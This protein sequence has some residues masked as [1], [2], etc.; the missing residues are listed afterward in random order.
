MIRLALVPWWGWVL[1]TLA[2]VAGV[3]GYGSVRHAAGKRIG[4]GEV[5]AQW[6][7]AVERG[8]A[9]VDRLKAAAGRVTTRVETKY[10]DRI[11]TIRE[12]GDA[13]VREVPVFVPAGSCDLPGG[14]RLLHDA[15]AAAGP[16][17]EAAGIADA[18]PVPAQ[19]AIATVAGNYATCHEDAARLISLQE[20]AQEQ[21][22]A[23]PPP[24]GCGP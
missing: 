7:A 6:D 23:N 13:I 22:E 14:F 18:A 15:A 24:E 1:A 9:E 10:V 20:W 11:V 19:T 5:Q 3:V 12:K 21:C 2:V 4:A 8:R 17:P 16:V